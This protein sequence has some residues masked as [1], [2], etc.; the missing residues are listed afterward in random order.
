MSLKS[1]MAF[2]NKNR[3]AAQKCAKSTTLS[4]QK[5]VDVLR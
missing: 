3:T 1:C 2:A 4:C 5:S